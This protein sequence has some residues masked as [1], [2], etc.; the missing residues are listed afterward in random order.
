MT[1][2]HGG[3]KEPQQVPVGNPPYVIFGVLSIPKQLREAGEI[4]DGIH[5]HRGELPSEPAV[6]V[7]ADGRVVGAGF[8]VGQRQ[9]LTCAHVVAQALSLPGDTLETPHAEVHLDFPLVTPEQQ[10]AARVVC[11]QPA[12][13]NGSGDVAG[14]EL[15]DDPPARASPV[16]LVRTEEPWGHPFRAF[17]FPTGFDNG[18]WASGRMLGREATG[19]LQIEDVKQTGYF[20]AP[21]F[22]GGPVWDETLD[23]VVGMTVAA[24]TRQGVRAAFIIPT[25]RLVAAWP[26]LATWAIPPCP[27]RG[28]L[29]FREQD[30]PFFFGREAFT[31]R[32]VETVE[33]HALTVAVVGPS[34]SGKSSVVFA[35]LLPRLQQ[36]HNK[37]RDEDWTIA[38]LRPGSQPFDELANALLPLLE[39]EMTRTDRLI[40]VPK[41]AG[42]LR[43]GDVALPRVAAEILEQSLDAGHLLLVIDQ[44][45]ELYTLCPDPDTRHAFLDCLI[46]SASPTPPHPHTPLHLVLTLRAD[47]LGQALSYR[48]FAD[49]LDRAEKLILGPMNREELEAA[50]VRP[51]ER[52]GV[53]VLPANRLS[54]SHCVRALNT[55]L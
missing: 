8:L 20:V 25:D 45:E 51:A 31:E 19:W 18:V 52:Q 35:G 53:E 23:G 13:P 41:L 42:A 7:A 9:V 34:G 28:L 50:I 49:A 11:W 33:G 43:Q 40:E 44:F 12:H 21:G 1:R 55:G 15:V 29:A 2:L 32:L 14:L 10:L 54:T 48:P 37:N 47:F 46:Q 22:S 5:V 38:R 6:E 39:P 24:D 3:P 26:T 36:A 17:G 16:R 4:G 27:Y 30:A